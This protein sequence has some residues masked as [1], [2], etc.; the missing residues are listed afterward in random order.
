MPRECP[1]ANTLAT[2]IALEVKTDRGAT[3][4]IDTRSPA[5]SRRASTVSSAATPPPA[6]TT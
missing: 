5:R 1:R 4:V 6:I 3:I 2:A